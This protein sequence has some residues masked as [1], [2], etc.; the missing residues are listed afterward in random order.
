V[1]QNLRSWAPMRLIRPDMRT[2]VSSYTDI[3]T[4]KSYEGGKVVKVCWDVEWMCVV[5]KR[6][7]RC[8]CC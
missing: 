8:G 5:V 7:H 4:K 3:D 6:L 1:S 2:F